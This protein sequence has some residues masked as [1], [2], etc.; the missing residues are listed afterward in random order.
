MNGIQ[1]QN[2]RDEENEP[3]KRTRINKTYQANM[4]YLR[5]NVLYSYGYLL[6]KHAEKQFVGCINAYKNSTHGMRCHGIIT[7]VPKSKKKP[8]F[9]VGL[10]KNNIQLKNV[11]EAMIKHGIN[12]WNAQWTV[13]PAQHSPHDTPIYGNSAARSPFS[14]VSSIS[15]A[16]SLHVDSPY[17][18]STDYSGFV[19]FRIQMQQKQQQQIQQE[20]VQQGQE[21]QQQVQ[22][23]QQV[24]QVQQE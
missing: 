11:S 5:R 4:H 24:Q 16:S 8:F 19:P 20:Q 10:S 22:Q 2:E 23:E 7:D 14:G 21:Q 9:V 1:D 6:A 18:P 3:A 17:S 13:A 15:P 12:E